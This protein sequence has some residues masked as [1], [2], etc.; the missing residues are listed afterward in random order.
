VVYVYPSRFLRE[1]YNL[2]YTDGSSEV[3]HR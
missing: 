1:N 3:F 2:V